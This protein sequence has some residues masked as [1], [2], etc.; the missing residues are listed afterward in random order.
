M[1]LDVIGVDLFG[2]LSRFL[3]T[4][5]VATA[6]SGTIRSMTMASGWWFFIGYLITLIAAGLG[7]ASGV[8]V[9]ETEEHPHGHARRAHTD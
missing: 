3:F 6:P 1:L 4:Q 7:G 9:E 8:V 5:G 2:G